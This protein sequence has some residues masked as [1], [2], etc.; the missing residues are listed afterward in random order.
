MAAYVRQRAHRPVRGGTESLWKISDA[1]ADYIEKQLA[2]I[3]GIAIPV[4]GLVGKWKVRPNRPEP[5]RA[6]LVGGLRAAG[7]AGSAAMAQ[8]VAQPGATR[9]GG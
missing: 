6:G 8:Q 4:A 3:V 5:D 7:D 9:S 2:A 1:P